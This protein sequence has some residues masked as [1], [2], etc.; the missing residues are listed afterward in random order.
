MKSYEEINEKIKKGTGVVVTAD[1]MTSLVREIGVKKA[2]EKVDIVT[3][4]TFGPMCSS[5]IIINFG[6]SDVPTK[7]E[8]IILNDVPVYGGLASADAYI[9]ATSRSLHNQKYGGAHV[10]CDLV[11]KKKI[12]LEVQGFVTDCK[13]NK[14]IHGYIDIN[15]VNECIMFN[16]RN[17]YQNYNA[18]SNSSDKEL[19][20]YLGP[21][22]KCCGNIA[23]SGAGQ[24]S[25][26]LNDPYLRTIGIGTKIFLG[27]AEGFVVWNG[28]QFNTEK[29]LSKQNIPLSPART[30]SV[31]GNL[32]D[33]DCNYLKPICIK[34]YGITLC[35]GLGIPIPILD[36]EMAYYTSIG[37]EDILTNVLDFASKN[38]ERPVIQKVSYKEL[39]SRKVNLNGKTIPTVSFSS[40]GIAKNIAH[41]LKSKI[42]SR[43]FCCTEFVQSLPSYSKP[44]SLT[45]I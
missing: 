17:S 10:I 16:P 39:K 11:K 19:F 32:K 30:I 31:I 9:G 15:S 27:G 45:L 25:P 29:P 40:I 23:Y 18:A 26:L 21:L 14:E 5:G 41:T 36:E 13:P 35:V 33:M 8:N 4:G 28:T 6:Q 42:I 7:M 20:T 3:T 37:D 22:K 2:S 44:G 1:E 43:E 24:L 12:K 34:G 38:R